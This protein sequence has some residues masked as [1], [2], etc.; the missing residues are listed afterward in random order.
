M[1]GS[2]QTEIGLSRLPD[3]ARADATRYLTRSGNA[4]LLPM[5]GLAPDI[6]DGAVLVDGA[7]LHP[8]CGRPMPK[9][10]RCRQG[11][12]CRADDD[13]ARTARGICSTCGKPLPDPVTNGGRKPCQRKRCAAGPVARGVKR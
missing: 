9:S 2:V 6:P 4:D 12:Q 10:G 7:I 13:R 3:S 5:L 11:R 8:T 1:S